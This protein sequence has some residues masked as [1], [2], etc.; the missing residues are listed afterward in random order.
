MFTRALE[1]LTS[2]GHRLEALLHEYPIDLV[3]NFYRAALENQKVELKSASLGM[4]VAVMNALDTAFG[5]GE[6]NILGKWCEVLDGTDE[7]Q[8]KPASPGLK[9]FFGEAPVRAK[10]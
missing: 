4:S 8:A 6:A 10:E 2:R 7:A 1:A 9:K 5:S 3:L